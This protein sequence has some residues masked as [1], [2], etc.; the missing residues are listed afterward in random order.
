MLALVLEAWGFLASADGAQAL[1]G[2]P[3]APMSWGSSS[4]ITGSSVLPLKHQILPGR[5]LGWSGFLCA[6][7]GPRPPIPGTLLS[8]LPSHLADLR[9]QEP[10]A[11]GGDPAACHPHP[12]AL[13]LALLRHPH[14][15]R[16]VPAP[17]PP[18]P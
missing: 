15:H 16:A 7:R 12:P 6:L 5:S 13:L 14:Q 8:S 17:H 2:A 4:P 18:G 1:H 10:A 3:A 9:Q 11:R